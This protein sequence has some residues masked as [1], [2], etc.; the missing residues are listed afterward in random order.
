M[1][2]MDWLKSL[3][4]RSLTGFVLLGLLSNFLEADELEP[5]PNEWTKAIS[6]VE[7]DP[8]PKE[9]CL[10]AHFVISDEGAHYLFQPAIKDLQGIFIGVGT[11]Q[12]YLMAGWARSEFLV[13]MDFDQVIVDLHKVYRAFFLSAKD[14]KEFIGLWTKEKDAID[15]LVKTYPSEKKAVISA[16]KLSR[17]Q[18]E[19]RLR[20]LQRR[21]K[22]K[23]VSTFLDDD[24]QYQHIV[25]LFKANRVLIIRGDLTGKKALSGIGRVAK[26]MGMPVRVLYLSNA[27]GYF[28]YSDAF[29]DNILNLP[30][31]NK[32]I[33]LRTSGRGEKGSGDGHYHY[34]VQK[35]LNFVEWVRDK[36]IIKYYPLLHVAK[37]DPKM[38][39]LYY[40]EA[41]PPP[42]PKGK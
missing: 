33:V 39:G 23:N 35:A 24:Q 22:Q 1:L 20:S 21:Y 16:Y 31:D 12:N 29:R 11:D 10:N 17:G 42:K 6:S 36:R 15:L 8:P 9:L 40:I 38:T 5:I 25:N 3:V 37:R 41:Y 26:Q 34:F 28:R 14:I 7:P 13:L 27:E 2:S 18:V 30:F 4:Q 19:G 32:S